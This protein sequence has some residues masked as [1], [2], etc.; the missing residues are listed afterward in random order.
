ME[1]LVSVRD[2]SN[3]KVSESHRSRN[4][5]HSKQEWVFSSVNLYRGLSSA[6]IY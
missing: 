1:M 5:D 2:K 3:E 4:L 6:S